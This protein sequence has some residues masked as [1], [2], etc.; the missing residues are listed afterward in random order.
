MLFQRLYNWIKYKTL[1]PSILFKNRLFIERDSKHRRIFSNFGLTFRNSKWSNYAT[2]NIKSQFKWN[3]MTIFLFLLVFFLLIFFIFNFKKYYIFFYCFNSFSFLFW[4]SIDAFDYYLSFIVWFFTV[5]FSLLSNIV[6]TFFFFNNF[7]CDKD[8]KILFENKFFNKIYLKNTTNSGIVT[9]SK[10]DAN[11]ILY[12]WLTNTTTK[13]TF[14]FLENIFTQKINKNFWTS[15][16][17]FFI[18]LY[19]IT[20]LCNLSQETTSIFAINTF[21]N[22]FNN[23][24]YRGNN[25]QLISFLDNSNNLTQF[26]SFFLH[27][28]LK[29]SQNYF[30]QNVS[31]S[32]SL[33]FIKNRFE[34]NSSLFLVELIKNN[35]LIN[36][37]TG[38]FFFNT[39]NYGHLNSFL[40]E[41]PEL[42]L[43]TSSLSDQLN[44]AKWNRWLYRYSILHRKIL[45]NSHKLTLSKH[46]ITSGFYNSSLF[47]KNIWAS[48]TFLKYNDK[49]FIFN[50]LYNLYNMNYI[51]NSSISMQTSMHFNDNLNNLKL[52]NFYENS[53]FW[54]LKRYYFLNTLSSNLIKTNFN[55]SKLNN[56]DI[57][58]DFKNSNQIKYFS[59]TN[60]FLN[61]LFFTQL[62]FSHSHN[63]L[64]KN[65]L[66]DDNFFPSNKCSSANNFILKDLYVLY[67]ESD[68]LNKENLNLSYWISMPMSHLNLNLNY[69]S[70]LQ[71]QSIFSN[72]KILCFSLT[73]GSDADF[74]NYLYLSLNN[75]DD[76]F[77]SDLNFLSFF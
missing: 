44:A 46:L 62:N 73:K 59:L 72:D 68:L 2:Y 57:L 55:K 76:S 30:S 65:V 8:T 52:L 61:S 3:F 19:K 60:Y 31:K 14:M 28:M 56:F 67:G 29:N 43:L 77:L 15:Y 12:S 18:K 4:I 40:N 6:Y 47:T 16:Y 74:L 71:M 42:I 22:Q 27:Y 35:S 25:F 20:Y 51:K 69:F 63:T 10:H 45:K 21:L 24:N 13:N 9:L 39:F 41:Y 36:F 58:F 23:K 75:V 50:S 70:Y 54:F 32:N 26:S 66:F 37:K 7:S 33:T 34:W 49:D 5:F 38:F 17:D 53:Y 11:W 64:R 48:L 1:P